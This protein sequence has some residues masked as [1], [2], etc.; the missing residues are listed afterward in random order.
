VA[1]TGREEQNKVVGDEWEGRT[2]G[3]GGINVLKP[4]IARGFIFSIKCIKICL[5]AGLRPDP[6]GEACDLRQAPYP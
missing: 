2:G 6:L 1:G 3:A 5:A 4:I